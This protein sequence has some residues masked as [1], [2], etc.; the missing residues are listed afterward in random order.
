MTEGNRRVTR[1][2]EDDVLLV[3][4]YRE[5]RMQTFDGGI[6]TVEIRER[7]LT[8]PAD[9][10]LAKQVGNALLGF[11]ADR[12]STDPRGQQPIHQQYA[13]GEPDR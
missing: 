3:T 5:D 4:V 8:L 12:Q 11:H 1:T 9:P 13:Q 2:V 7:T 10:A 6:E